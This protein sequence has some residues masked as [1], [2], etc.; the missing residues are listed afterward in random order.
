MANFNPVTD[1]LEKDNIVEASAGTGKT[2]SI[3][4]IVLRLL[5]EK[6][7]P[8]TRILMVTFTNAAVA[9]LASRIRKF[10]KKAIKIIETKQV[11]K[12]YEDIFKIVSNCEEDIAIQIL[13]K[14]LTDLDEAS[15]Q[16]IHS[17]CQDSLNSFA[18]NSGQAFGLE[19]QPD[20]L[21]L[22]N[23][24]VKEFWRKEITVLP[25]E[26]LI[27]NDILSLAIFQAAVKE[28]LGGKK[29]AIEKITSH[30]TY[31]QKNREFE[32]HVIQKQVSLIHKI[33]TTSIN[34]F[35]EKQQKT[36][37]DL[38][39][40]AEYFQNWLLSKTTSKYIH[41]CW[42][43]IFPLERKMALEIQECGRDMITSYFQRCI[44]YVHINLNKYLVEKQS[45]TYDELINRMHAS[46]VCK[47]NLEFRN[48]I[49]DKYD[50]IFIDE[51][52]DTDKLQYEIYHQLFGENKT[53]FYIGDPKQSIYAW[54]KA[55]LHTY[56][57]AKYNIPKE[58]QYEMHTNYRSTKDYIEALENFYS[59]PDPFHTDRSNLNLNFIAVDANDQASSG[60]IGNDMKFKPLEIYDGGKVD[61]IKKKI[62]LLI[63]ELLK[64]DGY[65]LNGEQVKNSDIGIL[66]RK[67]R[68]G[69]EI[70]RL[71]AATGIHAITLDDA[72]VYKDSVEGKSLSHILEAVLNTS[73]RNILKALI[74]SFTG[75]NSET[76]A[77]LNI[78]DLL[79]VFR[80]YRELW[81]KSGIYP[82]M[83]QFMSDFEVLSRLMKNENGNELRI[84]SNLNQ[85]LELL[86]KAETRQDLKPT[87]LYEY[88][89]KQIGG[90]M[91]QD[92]EYQQRM[93][94]D[95]DAVKI[96]TIH[97]SKGLEYPIVI[98]PFLDLDTTYRNHIKTLSFKEEIEEGEYRFCIK[99]LQNKEQEELI[100]KQWEQENRRLIYVALTRAKYNCF[101]FK[102]NTKKTALSHYLKD[103]DKKKFDL[104]ELKDQKPEDDTA[105]GTNYSDFKQVTNFELADHNYGKISFSALSAHGAYL[106]K[107]N[108][109][110]PE[111]YDKF[112]FKTIPGGV[113][114]GTMLH[115]LFEN[116]DF[117][118]EA[119]Q[120]KDELEKLLEGYYPHL[121]E[122]LTDGFLEMVD[123]VL[124][125]RIEIN[126]EQIHLKKI[127]NAKKRNEM[128]FDLSIYDLDLRGLKNFDAGEGIEINCNLQIGA[129]EGLLNGLIDLFFEHNG[130]YYILD[131]KSN[132][133][134]DHLDYYAAGDTMKKALNEGNYHLQYLIYSMAVKNYLEARLP[135]FDYDKH[136]GGVIYVYLRGARKGTEHGIYTN[137][138]SLEQ[139]ETLER[140]FQ[141][142]SPKSI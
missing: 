38:L 24:K 121:K 72:Q 77:N 113:N 16:T 28:S 54:R 84:L 119:D 32:D 62:P 23:D 124:D 118:G 34:R 67:N 14:S 87:A 61:E 53:L 82:M 73:E 66:V 115:Y 55:D 5:L 52:Q 9:E 6:Q 70:K 29:L 116:I 64:K 105:G 56:F 132:Y 97:K 13:Q 43:R 18:L 92:D 59:I 136:F 134:G 133:L 31:L 127:S 39:E 90:E 21:A 139:V 106:P 46:I 48:A 89:N 104:P 140:I 138:P 85:I 20:I 65:K 83:K 49:R 107:E 51:F 27:E 123:H 42:E 1:P 76:A 4:L 141:E 142:T 36:V 128:E 47:D 80:G 22:A 81:N 37:I 44:D 108:D 114:L 86:Q 57:Q 58:R 129:K 40:H 41:E 91:N 130:K 109:G 19:L 135:E 50:A 99:S 10:I 12:G 74:N 112:I 93:E 45:I 17:F 110:S 7:I 68:E 122:G 63:Q 125:S 8:I 94:S 3:G 25:E 88:L 71:L 137:R 131:W 96:V 26:F 60:L 33:E 126:G 2:F 69:A 15:I 95:E 102:S 101:L 103:A 75:Y 117:T 35:K 78:E 11:E 111:D 98:A 30:D 120:H 79:D 100:K